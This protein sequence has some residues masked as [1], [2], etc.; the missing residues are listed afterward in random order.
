MDIVAS[1]ILCV[2]FTRNYSTCCAVQFVLCV[3]HSCQDRDQLNSA[4][5]NFHLLLTFPPVFHSVLF[6]S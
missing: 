6:F 3:T 2:L 1:E 5:L 4:I